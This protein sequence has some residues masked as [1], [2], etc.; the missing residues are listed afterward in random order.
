MK[1]SILIICLCF[2]TLFSC[3]SEIPISSSDSPSTIETTAEKYGYKI[4]KVNDSI[5]K[6]ADLNELQNLLGAIES[7]FKNPKV[8]T[9]GNNLLPIEQNS[10]ALNIYEKMIAKKKNETVKNR[11][12]EDPPYTHSVSFYFDNTFPCSNVYVT[13]NYNVNSMGQITAA[14]IGTGS[15]GFSWG[16][17]YSQTNVNSMLQNGIFVFQINGQLNTS[18]GVSSFSLNNSNNVQYTGYLQS[19]GGGGDSNHIR[20]GACSQQGYV[21]PIAN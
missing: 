9:I 7:N 14:S 11:D 10:E 18:V 5:Y 15:Y 13:I 19:G 17:T 2:L 21:P 4:S 8:K 16:N 1:K 3:T 6:V 12:G 20:D